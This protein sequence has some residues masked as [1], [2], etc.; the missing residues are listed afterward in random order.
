MPKRINKF[1]LQIEKQKLEQEY[2]TLEKEK[3]SA[4]AIIAC[5]TRKNKIED[6]QAEI[7]REVCKLEEEMLEENEGYRE[8]KNE[9]I[10]KKLIANP[11]NK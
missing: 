4:E 10:V 1:K 2:L 11:K 7:Q 3:N 9:K 8:K 6:R 5:Q